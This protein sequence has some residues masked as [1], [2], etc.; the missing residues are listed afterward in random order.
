M[1]GYT[2]DPDK[3]APCARCKKD[4]RLHPERDALWV[5]MVSPECQSWSQ[6]GLM[7]GWLDDSNLPLLVWLWQ[8]LQVP[9]A[10]YV[11]ECV[12]GLDLEFISLIHREVF[13]IS[14]AVFSPIDLGLPVAGERLYVVAIK[15]SLEP[16][17]IMRLIPPCRAISVRSVTSVKGIVEKKRS[18]SLTTVRLSIP[19]CSRRSRLQAMSICA[20]VLMS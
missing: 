18:A 10:F 5:D 19:F 15:K 17:K 2:F 16:M 11:M 20:Q 14:S 7:Q 9:P 12:P 8:S 13:T 4:C 3:K 1:E 6:Q